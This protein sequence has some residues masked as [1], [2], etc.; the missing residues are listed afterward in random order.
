MI[1][2]FNQ[3]Y[4]LYRYDLEEPP[5]QWDINY[6]SIE[7]A[8]E[9]YEDKTRL[10]NQIGACFFYDNKTQAY[11]TGCV[12]AKNKGKSQFWITHTSIIP[13]IVLLDLSEHTTASGVRKP[14][15]T[16]FEVLSRLDEIGFDIL[17][18]SFNK[19]PDVSGN[20]VSL[21]II[22]SLFS[23]VRDGI[24]KGEDGKVIRSYVDEINSFFN[25][26]VGYLGQLLTDFENGIHF[27][28]LLVS[29][30]LNGY[31]FKEEIFTQKPTFCILDNNLLGLPDVQTVYR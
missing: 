4:D 27:K 17:N 13:P 16:P 29:K 2:T 11:L 9:G 15:S 22:R 1:K 26:S 31:I 30:K 24:I 7:Y 20:K 23:T 3:P 6:H 18:N 21:A 12:A 25:D 5:R 10:K 19:F 28:E 8:Y 14:Y